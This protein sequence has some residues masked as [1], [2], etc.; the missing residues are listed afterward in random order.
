MSQ[1]SFEQKHHLINKY[2]CVAVTRCD[3]LPL[4]KN[5]KVY[6]TTCTEEKV[7]FTA[8]CRVRCNEGYQLVGAYDEYTCG[9]NKVWSPPLY[10]IACKRNNTTLN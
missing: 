8:K 10:T 5:G 6:P 2:N 1:N 7:R 3:E 9:Y 4:V